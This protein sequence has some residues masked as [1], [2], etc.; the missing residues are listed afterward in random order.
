MAVFNVLGSNETLSVL[1][2]GS[3]GP[4][5]KTWQ[6]ALNW[7][8]RSKSPIMADG[9]FGNATKAATIELQRY[10]KITADGI[11]GPQTVKA[12]QTRWPNYLARF[13]LTE[14]VQP[15]ATLKPSTSDTASWL[16]EQIAA[17]TA[18]IGKQVPAPKPGPAPVYIPT[19]PQIPTYQPSYTPQPA[20]QASQQSSQEDGPLGVPV[21]AW[22]G[23]AGLALV[24]VMKKKQG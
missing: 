6:N 3:R 14:Q 10:L 8:V 1:K 16:S 12:Y 13:D 5:V 21:I 22:I 19:V 11:V 4:A 23:L 18:N 15:G 7:T 9:I 17:S 2:V 20:F 24:V